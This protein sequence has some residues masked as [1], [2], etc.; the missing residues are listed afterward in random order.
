V[1]SAVMTMAAEQLP[2]TTT[3]AF[4]LKIATALLMMFAAT[5]VLVHAESHF[6]HPLMTRDFMSDVF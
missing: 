6:S 4:I 5:L 3:A 2:V 1:E